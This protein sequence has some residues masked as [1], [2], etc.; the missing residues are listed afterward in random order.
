M[1][2]NTHRSGFVQALA[3][4]LAEAEAKYERLKS[5][6]KKQLAELAAEN[7]EL[8]RRLQRYE[9]GAATSTSLSRSALG[10]VVVA[11]GGGGGRARGPQQLQNLVAVSDAHLGQNVI[12]VDAVP[13]AVDGAACA[14]VVMS[15]G[16]DKHIRLH[17]CVTTTPAGDTSLTEL[18]SLQLDAPVVDLRFHPGCFSSAHGSSS[19]LAAIALLSGTVAVVAVHVDAAASPPTAHLDMSWVNRLHTRFATRTRW[20]ADG[21][22]LA[23]CS[24]DK[25]VCMLPVAWTAGTGGADGTVHVDTGATLRREFSAAVAAIEFVQVKGGPLAAGAN[26]E[27]LVV[28]VSN[29]PVLSYLR[30]GAPSASE[31]A[32]VGLS[33]DSPPPPLTGG[34]GHVGFSVVDLAVAPDGHALAVAADHGPV[35]LYTP[36]TS[37]IH[38]RV[39]AHPVGPAAVARLAWLPDN[40]TLLCSSAVDHSV[41]VFNTPSESLTGATR[42]HSARVRAVAHCTNFVFTVSYDKS[43]KVWRLM[44]GAK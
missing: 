14:A 35:F 3:E 39:A 5:S 15:G 19:T 12:A 2:L 17:L 23:T 40:A 22:V 4:A 1:S 20:S 42:V 16:A 9:A 43:V 21:T 6:S 38:T 26:Q 7:T 13:F 41:M 44:D 33:E 32:L 11:G 18:S 8:R 29:S 30:V 31:P 34:F 24:H 37:T 25:T 10:G 28:A 36:G 27:F